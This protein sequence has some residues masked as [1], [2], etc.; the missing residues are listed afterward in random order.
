MLPFLLTIPA[1]LFVLLRCLVLFSVAV[2]N[3]VT[4][5]ETY[6]HKRTHTLLPKLIIANS[7]AESTSQETTLT[8]RHDHLTELFKKDTR[9]AQ[10]MIWQDATTIQSDFS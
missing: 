5:T 8:F 9:P 10:K 7:T 1:I 2:H 4:R 3:I 6:L